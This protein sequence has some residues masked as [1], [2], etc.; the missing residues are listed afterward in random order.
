MSSNPHVKR[1]N[2]HSLK[3]CWLN[4][5]SVDDYYRL[6]LVVLVRA[7]PSFCDTECK[8]LA[9]HTEGC[10][11]SVCHQQLD[12]SSSLR[13]PVHSPCIHRSGV[14][15]RLDDKLPTGLLSILVKAVL[16]FFFFFNRTPHYVEHE[17]LTCISVHS[18][19]YRVFFIP[20]RFQR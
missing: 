5:H 13:L 20:H 7:S 19:G 17:Q 18:G 3:E 12:V 1:S 10:V 8:M 11:A 4:E 14:N 15:K 9:L 16:S 6:Y 2:V